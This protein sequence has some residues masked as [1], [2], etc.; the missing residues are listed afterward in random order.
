M[1]RDFSE[2]P[3]V[4]MPLSIMLLVVVLDQ[5]S[6]WRV[7]TTFM[8]YESREVVP[9]FFNLTYLRNTGAAFGFLA[10]NHGMW[11]QALFVGIAVVALVFMFSA[12]F[13]L[14][15]QGRIF[16][17]GLGLIGGGAVGNLIDRIFYGGLVVDFIDLGVGSHRFYTF[18]V[19][20]MGVTI[21]GVILFLCLLLDGRERRE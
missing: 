14:R 10:G 18:N 3:T 11:R 16:V 20:D 12:F 5:L 19:A 1:K 6:K 7:I 13:Y 4:F 8:L 15:G 9:G 17:C 2:K 21:G